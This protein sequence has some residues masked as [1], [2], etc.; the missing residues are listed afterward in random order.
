VGDGRDHLGGRQ[1]YVLSCTRRP[2]RHLQV[3]GMCPAQAASGR[4][5]ADHDQVAPRAVSGN[6]P[7]LPH[8]WWRFLVGRI[9]RDTNRLCH[10]VS[11]PPGSSRRQSRAHGGTSL[12]SHPRDRGTRA[13]SVAGPSPSDRGRARSGETKTGALAWTIASAVPEC[14][15]NG[16][17]TAA[18]RNSYSG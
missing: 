7:E 5:F 16:S 13:N 14:R 11:Q 17:P 10:H 4:G 3:R 12:R 6:S 18:R 2:G 8:G 15:C 9:A 1:W